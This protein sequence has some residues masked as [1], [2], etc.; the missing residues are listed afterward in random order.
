MQRKAPTLLDVSFAICHLSARDAP[1]T[2]NAYL[3]REEAL[4]RY[5]ARVIF[6]LRYG[7]DPHGDDPPSNVIAPD[8]ELLLSGRLRLHL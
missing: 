3:R 1:T 2:A 5:R 7:S 4:E 8:W 6:G